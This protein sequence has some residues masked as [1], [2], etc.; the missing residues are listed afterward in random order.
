MTK[1]ITPNTISPTF[2]PACIAGLAAWRD[3]KVWLRVCAWPWMKSPSIL[4]D[5]WVDVPEMPEACTMER[6]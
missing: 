5:I 4:P 1:A 2:W 3:N 6:R